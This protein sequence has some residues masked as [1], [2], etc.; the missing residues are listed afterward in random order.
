MLSDVGPFQR[1]NQVEPEPRRQE[2]IADR[3]CGRIVSLS[4]VCKGTWPSFLTLP[5]TAAVIGAPGQFGQPLAGTDKGPDLLRDA[6]LHQSLATLGWRVEEMG[7]V[8]RRL[9]VSRTAFVVSPVI[10]SSAVVFENSALQ[11][12]LF[13]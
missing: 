8:V 2:L 10:G 1:N 9:Y 4:L 12:W 3:S 13:W 5:R 7:D 11:Q 6:G